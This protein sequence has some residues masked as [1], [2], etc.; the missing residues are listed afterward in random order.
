M[1]K[2]VTTTSQ[3]SD[4]S[5]LDEPVAVGRFADHFDITARLQGGA[6]PHQDHRVIV[7]NDRSQNH[8]F[9]RKR[10]C[11]AALHEMCYS[12]LPSWRLQ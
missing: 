4:A 1:E 5:N 8:V 6:G 10:M 2:S 3:G 9:P 11:A 7:G 12:V